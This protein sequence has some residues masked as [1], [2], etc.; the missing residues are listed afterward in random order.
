MERKSLPTQ[1]DVGMLRKNLVDGRRRFAV[2]NEYGYRSYSLLHQVLGFWIRHGVND[3]KIHNVFKLQKIF[4][5]VHF[6]FVFLHFETECK[7]C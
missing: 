1:Y 4:L 7:Y 2:A 6:F 5:S 3:A